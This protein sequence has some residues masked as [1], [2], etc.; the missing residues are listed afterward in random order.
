MTGRTI[1][2]TIKDIAKQC[3]VSVSTV[4]RVLNDRPDVSDE[5]RRK[6]R[7]AI[8]DS[9][10]IP[11]NS[12]RDLVRT[13]SESIGLV[14][15][16]VSNPFYT[17]I[18]QAIEKTVTDAGF[19]LVMQQIPSCG[20]EVQRAAIMER[21][22]RLQGIIFLGGRLDYSPEDL[23]MLN[24]PYV[25]CSYSNQYGTLR[26]GEYSAVSIA[27]EEA[28][29]QAVDHLYGHGHR[30]IAALI[31]RPD[32]QSISQLRYQGYCKALSSHGIPL[33]PELVMC[34]GSFDIRDAYDAVCE[35]LRQ[36]A[37][38]TALFAI[39]DSMA[40]GAMRALRDEGRAVPQDC[41]V[42][43]IDGLELSAYIEPPLTT[44]CQPMEEMGQRSAQ[45]LLG[46]IHGHG[47]HCCEVLPTRLRQGGSVQDI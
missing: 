2:M 38:F 36:G 30:R 13:K 40:I 27:D 39:A 10:Y 29:Q 6:V 7:A 24:V 44:L 23:A 26:I 33:D 1:G 42:I 45:I 3:S 41:S 17:D 8:K 20:D 18:I 43:A 19:S 4:S 34:A 11:N 32:D 46:L 16:G 31:C 35:K 37:E 25:C 12:A 5:V 47:A 21:E 14:V 9:N 28:A 22:K 15:R